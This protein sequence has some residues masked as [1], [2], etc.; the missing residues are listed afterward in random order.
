M[1]YSIV[2]NTAHCLALLSMGIQNCIELC[3]WGEICSPLLNLK[4]I[5]NAAYFSV[6]SLKANMCLLVATFLSIISRKLLILQ[7][8]EKRDLNY[9][10]LC[11]NKKFD[12]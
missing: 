11:L 7:K 9:P 10:Q 4:L 12:P 6:L 3:G 1:L 2:F 5:L 8:L